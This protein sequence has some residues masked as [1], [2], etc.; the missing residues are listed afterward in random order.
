MVNPEPIETSRTLTSQDL[1]AILVGGPPHA[2]KSVLTYNLTRELRNRNIPHYVLRASTDVEGDWL[3]EGNYSI[4]TEIRKNARESYEKYNQ[5]FV[6]RV[7]SDLPRRHLPLIVDVGGKP[8]DGDIELFQNCTHSILLLKEKQVDDTNTWRH[9]IQINKKMKSIAELWSEQPKGSSLTSALGAPVV[10]GTIT[11]LEHNKDYI[12]NLKGDVVFDALFE[13]VATLFSQIPSD[14]LEQWHMSLAQGP[15]IDLT[16]ELHQRYPYRDLWDPRMLKPLFTSLSPAQDTLWVYGRAPN[17]LYGAL[18]LREKNKPFH[19]FD[20]RLGWISSPTL[21]THATLP[22]S[23]QETLDVQ[24]KPY[25]DATILFLHPTYHYLI[26]EEAE[27]LVFPEL[28]SEQGLI[29]NG[30]LPL[31]LF[32]ALARLYAQ[33]NMPWIAMNDARTNQPV[34]IYSRV[35]RYAIGDILPT[36]PR[37]IQL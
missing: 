35:A 34:V 3:A 11:H 24:E 13:R 9:Y 16:N 26:R 32:T 6:D 19:L 31:W 18:A 14:K 30:K 25:G 36:L 4:V 28:P 20:A 27:Q 17:W 5:R 29:L 15:I 10:T 12:S 33:R 21:Q 37:S 1:P 23:Q 2:G 22:V 8:K 7:C